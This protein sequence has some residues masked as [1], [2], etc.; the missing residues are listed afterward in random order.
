LVDIPPTLSTRSPALCGHARRDGGLRVPGDA[1]IRWRAWGLAGRYNSSVLARS[2]EVALA[3]WS[4][5]F[6]LAV[7]YFV[8]LFR[9]HRGKAVAANARDGY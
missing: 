2:L 6:P 3:W 7:F 5:G 9:I 8:A 4:V 1:S